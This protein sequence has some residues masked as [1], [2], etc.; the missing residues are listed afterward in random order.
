VTFCI[1][2]MQKT[3][4]WG[5][6]VDA[7]LLRRPFLKGHFIGIAKDLEDKCPDCTFVTMVRPADG[8][9]ESY[10]NHLYNFT[11]S[12][13]PEV[14]PIFRWDVQAR[15][16]VAIEILYTETEADFFLERNPSTTRAIIN[17]AD[18]AK[19]PISAFKVISKVCE[20]NYNEEIG[21]IA[22]AKMNE[23][24]AAKPKYKIDRKLEE[25]GVSRARLKE[26]QDPVIAKMIAA[27]YK[28]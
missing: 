10:C 17:F 23:S 3:V 19:D 14:P 20:L 8:R 1:A 11:A 9:I 16:G 12:F 25:L 6:T 5:S 26:L 18:F 27:A 2:L 28:I 15:A 21:E 13:T 24:R 7:D 4:F 22:V